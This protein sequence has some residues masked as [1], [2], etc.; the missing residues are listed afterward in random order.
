MEIAASMLLPDKAGRMLFDGMHESGTSAQLQAVATMT[1]SLLM[2]RSSLD[3][4]WLWRL[5]ITVLL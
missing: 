2:A 3:K 4:I 5:K 1:M